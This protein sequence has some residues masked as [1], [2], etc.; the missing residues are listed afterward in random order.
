M[1]VSQQSAQ[2]FKLH[3]LG[4]KAYTK[5]KAPKYVKDQA[6]RAKSGARK[7]YKKT[8]S[9][10][11][12]IDDETYVPCDPDDV[13]G[14]SFY[15]ATDPKAVPYSERIKP[16]AKFLKKYLVW[17]ALDANG[18]VSEPFVSQGTINSQVYRDEC[19][20]KR[21]LPFID[22]HHDRS[23]VIFWPDLA[24][25]HYASIVTTFL[26]SEN[27]EF[28]QKSSNPPNIPQARGIETFWA[29][30]KSEYSKRKNAPKNLK[31]FRTVWRNIS[32][33]VA[34][35][36]GKAVMEKGR[37]HLTKIG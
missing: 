15:H 34:E 8:L 37:K 3:E 33:K 1:N 14:R 9:Q 31:G 20:K 7:V 29:L 13:P 21:L 28:V 30:C 19:L 17:Q 32:K 26:R 23:E 12:V 6:K 5:K 27:V 35:K 10:I 22:K 24:T 18:N 16:K 36:S 25:S 4:R 2:N 11:L